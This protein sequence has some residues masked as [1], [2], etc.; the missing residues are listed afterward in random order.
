MKRPL[1]L[2][3]GQ[4]SL[5]R[6]PRADRASGSRGCCP[7][8]STTRTSSCAR[9]A[10]P[11][12]SPRCARPGSSSSRS[13]SPRR[14][15]ARSSSPRS[16]ARGSPTSRSPTPIACPSSTA[17]RC[18]ATCAWA[19]CARPPRA[20]SCATSDGNWSYDLAGSY[21]VNVFGL[22]FYKECIERAVAR[23]RELGPV[24]GPY[25]PVILDNV[26]RLREISG[27]DEVSFHMSGHRG[28]DAG[29]RARPLPHPPQPPGALLR[30]LPRLVGRRVSPAS[31]IR[32]TSATSTRSPSAATRRCACSRR[33][34]TSPACS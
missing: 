10:A 30:R 17:P 29:R 14:R 33:A 27:L 23:V 25:H 2:V 7:T 1:A 20:C 3:A 16:S 22:D 4:A 5:A 15:R 31:A 18:G 12:T 21:G 26:R 34:A 13:G 8:T 32:A 6:R 9:T 11:R 28:G 24:L 19:R